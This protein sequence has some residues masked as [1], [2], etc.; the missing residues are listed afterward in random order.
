MNIKTFNLNDLN[1][2]LI[3]NSFDDIESLHLLSHP[4]KENNMLV[5]KD[6]NNDDDNDQDNDNEYDYDE[7]VF[8]NELS[9][10][11]INNNSGAAANDDDDNDG[12]IGDV[13]NPSLIDIDMSVAIRLFQDI[14]RD[15][16]GS[17]TKLELIVALKKN[18]G[19]AEVQ[20][21]CWLW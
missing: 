19:I 11:Y 17:V 18:P 20:M 2:I 9:S 1:D 7:E 5:L 4:Y 13:N 16:D 8:E 15:K 6:R 21:V 10:S 3:E 12:A 14:D